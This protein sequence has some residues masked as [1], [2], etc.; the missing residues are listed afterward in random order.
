MLDN[1]RILFTLAKLA[2]R[3]RHSTGLPIKSFDVHRSFPL[4]IWISIK[5]N[6]RL[7]ARRDVAIVAV[8]VKLAS[9]LPVDW[10]RKNPTRIFPFQMINATTP[11]FKKNNSLKST[12]FILYTRRAMKCR[13]SEKKKKRIECRIIEMNRWLCLDDGSNIGELNYGKYLLQRC[14][15]WICM[16][17]VFGMLFTFYVFYM[18]NFEN[19][20]NAIRSYWRSIVLANI[21]IACHCNPI[22]EL[23]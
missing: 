4:S 3:F 20:T 8:N 9:F 18:K 23:W 11:M 5:R 13:S 14:C 22:G 21:V 6:S 17:P 19:S 12:P 10:R 7:A 1:R 16:T 2:V 15:V